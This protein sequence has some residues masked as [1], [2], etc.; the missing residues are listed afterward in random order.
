MPDIPN[1]PDNPIALEE[2]AQAGA[3][4][5]SPS[6]AR[7]KGLIA[8]AL[9]DLLAPGWRVLEF[10]SGTGEHAEQVCARR[11]DL[12]WTPSDPDLKSR[13]S[14]AARAAQSGGVIQ[15]PLDIDLSAPG[16]AGRA[17]RCDAIFCANTLHIAPWDAATGLAAGAAQLLPPHG[18]VI[19]YGPFLEGAESAPSNLAFS[20]DL[21][22]RD[23]R[24]GVRQRTDVEALFA[25]GG[26]SL[27]RALPMPANNMLL[28]FARDAAR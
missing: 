27:I 5:F 6:A 4:L 25:A 18:R 13:A 16:W 9:D 20:D 3:M 7:N 10:G 12:V 8:E 11:P 15:P 17:P 19:L 22:R 14:C 2:R 1:S 24:W 23:P 28:A 21:K 26:F